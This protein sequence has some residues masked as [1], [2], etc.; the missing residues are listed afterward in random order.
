M[1]LT[2]FWLSRSRVAGLHGK[3]RTRIARVLATADLA[4]RNGVIGA[5]LHAVPERPS[6]PAGMTPAVDAL[7]LNESLT[8]PVRMARVKSPVHGV[9][10]HKGRSR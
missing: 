8:P 9:H 5:R 7:A 3:P 10:V 1:L 2:V 6:G 4:A